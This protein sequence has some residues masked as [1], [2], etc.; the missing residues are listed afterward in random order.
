[1]PGTR[2]GGSSDSCSSST[3][4]CSGPSCSIR[5]SLTV[6]RPRCHVISTVKITA[7]IT[8]GNQPP[9]GTFVR[10]APKNAR[11]TMRKPPAPASTSHSG[12]CHSIRTTTKN[13]TVS[14][15]SVPVTAIP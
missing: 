13:S 14:I 9:C 11:S 8:S 15:A 12:L 3:N 1:M 10:L 4:A 2:A 6:S 5:R 7:A